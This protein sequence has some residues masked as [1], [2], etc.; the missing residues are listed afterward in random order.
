MDNIEL[1]GLVG[2]IASILGLFLGFAIC[3]KKYKIN[4]QANWFF[5]LFSFGDTNQSNDSKQ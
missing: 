4:T 1:I 5:S 2:S 3:K